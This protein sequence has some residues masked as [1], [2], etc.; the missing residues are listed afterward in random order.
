M[1]PPAIMQAFRDF[2][3]AWDPAWR[4]NPGKVIAPAPILSNLRLGSDYDPTEPETHFKYPDDQGSFARATLRCVGVG[5]CRRLDGGTMCPS[6]M[7]TR[8]EKDATRGR[9]HLLFEMLRGE[10]IGKQG[11]RDDSVKEALDLCLA[12]KGCKGDCPVNVDM[13]TYKAEFLSHYYEGRLRPRAAYSMGLIYWW[14]RVASKVPHLANF[15][16]RTP[17]FAAAAKMVG[18]IAPQRRMP[19][20]AAETFKDWFFKRSSRSAP[21]AGSS[22]GRTPSTTTCYPAPPRQRLRCSR[23]PAS[24]SSFRDGRCAADAR[25]MISGSSILPKR[26]LE[27]TLAVLRDEIRAGTP[28][29]GLEPSCVAVFR[30]ELTNLFPHDEDAQRMKRQTF[31]LGE[32]L[33]QEAPDYAVPKLQRRAIVHGHCHHKAVM[34]TG[35]EEALL[36]RMGIEYEVLDSGC[37]GM[38]GSFGFERDKFEVS[39]ACGERVLLPA[40]RE[41]AKDTLIVA[42]GFSCR[43]QIEQLTGRRALH[44][45]QVL[46]MAMQEGPRGPAGSYP[47]Q[48]YVQRTPAPLTSW[49]RALLG[50]VTAGAVLSSL[51]LGRRLSTRSS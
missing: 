5:K 39:V 47:E 7:V 40:V 48:A 31:T 10:V 2:K 46:Q 18:G 50:F 25:S 20:F 13:A 37:C 3:T 43:E 16:A 26:L 17:P 23:T 34:K 38:A 44:T 45:A 6:F 32:F 28:I 19:E 42:D 29:V 22:S 30:D 51:W 9:A 12:C 14:A 4:M 35:Q 41:A 49:E 8:E 33:L 15:L 21:G 24:R 11:W 27:Q 36:G 1:Y